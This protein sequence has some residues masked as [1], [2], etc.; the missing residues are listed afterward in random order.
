MKSYFIKSIATATADNKNFAGET[1]I[2]YIGKGTWVY[3][4]NAS[5]LLVEN[6]WSGK[7]WA[8]KFIE[9]DEKWQIR[10]VEELGYPKS[11]N[12]EYEIVEVEFVDGEN[13]IRVVEG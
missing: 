1:H 4:S 7:R 11:W 12:Y 2:H 6:G 13:V 3:D 10:L 5:L 8:K 9:D